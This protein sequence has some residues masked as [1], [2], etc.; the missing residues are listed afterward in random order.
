MDD[1]WFADHILDCQPGIQGA[2]WVLEYHA[3][4]ATQRFHLLL[5]NCGDIDPFA[6]PAVVPNL[7]GGRV[8]QAQDR[9]ADGRFAAAAFT[10]QTQHLA[11]A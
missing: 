9:T 1:E 11:L 10:D 6:I 3:H 4:L 8:V 7:A 5:A 2:E